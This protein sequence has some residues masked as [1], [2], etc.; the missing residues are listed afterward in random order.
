M[1]VTQ[2]S[3]KATIPPSESNREEEVPPHTYTSGAAFQSAN[4]LASPLLLEYYKK[5]QL[6]IAQKINQFIRLCRST[7]IETAVQHFVICR[8]QGR[9]ER[10]ER[11]RTTSLE[12]K[13]SRQSGED[14][15]I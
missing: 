3:D 13:T 11:E 4:S 7:R 6:L 5:K 1:I 10:G 12:G 14:A 8:C 2:V 9:R 15:S